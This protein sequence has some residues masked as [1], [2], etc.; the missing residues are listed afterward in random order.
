MAIYAK[1]GLPRGW[2]LSYQ[3]SKVLMLEKSVGIQKLGV[4]LKYEIFC[5]TNYP[6]LKPAPEPPVQRFQH[7]KIST[8]FISTT[9]SDEINFEHITRWLGADFEETHFFSDTPYR[10]FCTSIE[11]I[12]NICNFKTINPKNSSEWKNKKS[13]KYFPIHGI[14]LDIYIDKV[15]WVNLAILLIVGK[16]LHDLEL[17]KF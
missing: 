2:L 4:V 3:K 1:K 16:V 6:K 5:Q 8:Y 12:Y 9:F 15:I 7:N 10:T 14:H 13:Q 11:T 17:Q